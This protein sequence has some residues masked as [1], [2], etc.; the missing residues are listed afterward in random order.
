MMK[1]TNYLLT[2]I[3]LS[4]L[5]YAGDSQAQ[6]NT[7][8]RAELTYEN[9]FATKNPGCQSGT[10]GYTASGGTLT[11]NSADPAIVANGG[12]FCEWDSNAA[13]QT[14]SSELG[15]VP[16]TGNCEIGVWV[17]VPSGTATHTIHASDGTNNL[18][19]PRQITGTADAFFE[20][21]N[22]PCPSNGQAKWVITSVNANEP[23]ITWDNTR[24]GRAT[25]V[26][27]TTI[28]RPTT[29]FTPTGSWTTN[30]TY[31]GRYWQIGDR[32]HYQV[33]VALT[34]A[35]N[36]S[37][38]TIQ[39]LA[40]GF[41]ID[42]AKMVATTTDGRIPQADCRLR[43]AG[44]TYKGEGYY[45]GNNLA[46]TVANVASTYPFTSNA[47][48]A[49][50][51]TFT[52]G[53]VVICQGD[54]P[55]VSQASVLAVPSEMV[56]ITSMIFYVASSTCPANSTAADGTAISRTQYAS[57]FGR[58]G[59]TYGVGDGSTTFNKPDLRGIFVRGVGSQ[60]ISGQTYTGTLGTRQ[61]DQFQ[62]HSHGLSLDNRG[63]GV[64]NMAGGSYGAAGQT[65]SPSADGYGTPRVGTE[66]R[67]ANIGLTACI[68]LG[69]TM[70]VNL[71]N[72]VS[73]PLNNGA[74][75]IW[76]SVKTVCSASP[77]TIGSQSGGFSNITRASTGAYTANFEAGTFS[78]TPVCTCS[79]VGSSDGHCSAYGSTTSSSTV[80]TYNPVG[81]S[82]DGYIEMMCVGPR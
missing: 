66:T 55:I 44:I 1:F 54:V 58:I 43:A 18:T 69:P 32:Y 14:I 17:A 77:C 60:T 71:A 74:R 8:S 15:S 47:T 28:S 64:A 27:D 75:Y 19:Q 65:G 49:L 61:T 25:N 35:P 73:T 13:S 68:A 2:A 20:R 40:S 23:K 21:V 26:F 53:D 39:Y 7:M 63:A 59:T 22:F 16:K 72:S 80:R 38:L 29:S 31:S 42:T 37:S 10:V 12:T 78:G 52:N 81:S 30:T 51:G 57:L 34:G 70:G 4:S 56:D 46:V 9:G 6:L 45:N 62:S 24:G 36:S 5:I 48:Q 41:A 3:T 82:Q 11:V 67:P 76:A 33:Q 50:P 79:T